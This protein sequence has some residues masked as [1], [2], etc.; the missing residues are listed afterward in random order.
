M[1]KKY[2]S[3]FISLII[4]F[5][6]VVTILEGYFILCY[7]ESGKFLSVAKDLIQESGTITTRHFS[8]NFLY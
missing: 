7:F 2:S 6:L 5:M 8:N 1:H 4:K 3:N